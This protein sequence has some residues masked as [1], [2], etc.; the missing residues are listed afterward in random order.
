MVAIG[1]VLVQIGYLVNIGLD[2]KEF[3]LD[4]RFTFGLLSLVSLVSF[5]SFFFFNF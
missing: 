4:N 1:L 5:V 3:W 2:V